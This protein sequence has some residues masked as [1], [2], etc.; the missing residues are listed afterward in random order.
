MSGHGMTLQPA[1]MDRLVR[2]ALRED[3]GQ[4]GDITTD[5]T[6]PADAVAEARIVAR[7]AGT[8]AG[9][10][11]AARTFRVLDREVAFESRV[12]DGE[13]VPAGRP[14]ATLN[15]NARAILAGERTALNFLGHLSGIATTTA[16]F[17][18]AVRHTR[19]RILDTRKTTP[20]IRALEKYAV[21]AGGG[22]NH[23]F[24]LY[25][26]VLI[27]DNHIIVAGGVRQ[28]IE[29]ARG[30]APALARIEVEVETLAQLREAMAAGAEAVLLDNMDLTTLRQAVE[31]VDGRA[32]VE[33]SGGV[34]LESVG[35]IAATGVDYISVGHLT[36]SA[37]ALDVGLDLSILS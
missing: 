34:D 29:R 4:A 15:G 20:G 14:L 28:A 23:R 13:A 6:V 9:L 22:R 5:L 19:A 16:R 36:H 7:E 1:L 25:D 11:V 35:G 10:P 27:K 37:P 24:G 2:M 31:L 30:G 21:R 32:M 26:G 8:I 17:V 12:A 18:A 33:A 3:L